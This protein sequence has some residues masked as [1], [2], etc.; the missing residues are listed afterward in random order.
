VIVRH[1]GWILAAAMLWAARAEAQS[2]LASRLT[3]FLEE[4]Y[5]TS[6][7]LGHEGSPLQPQL[8]FSPELD[9]R[10]K[11]QTF[12]LGG[13]YAPILLVPHGDGAG[14]PTVDHTL[15]LDARRLLGPRL[16]V[17]GAGQ[18][19]RVTDPAHLPRQWGLGLVAA[20]GMI[21]GGVQGW[22][23]VALDRRWSVRAMYRMEAT[24][25]LAEGLAPGFLHAPEAELE[26]RLD[27]RTTLGALYRLQSFHFDSERSTSHGLA[28]HLV[29]RWTRTL[30]LEA[31]AGPTLFAQDGGGSG[32]H[33]RFSV[34]LLQEASR[35]VEWRLGAGHDLV[36]ASG[37][38]AAL[39]ASHVSG[40]V[41]WQVT[42]SVRLQGTVYAFRN[43]RLPPDGSFSW[44]GSGPMDHGLAASAGAAWSP[45]RGWSLQAGVGR[46]LQ[47]GEPARPGASFDQLSLQ[48]VFTAWE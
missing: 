2:T 26:H 23:R 36:G 27:R 46:F 11:G 31:H 17:G 48:V 7:L 10:W 44:W 39:M 38:A 33:P 8:R 24:Q 32:L 1:A 41:G 6:V 47:Q 34:S 13:R 42:P 19:W 9:A 16:E 28:A 20:E 40:M 18:L 37:M 21:S 14:S 5:A 22:A 29:H 45:G 3:V 15:A 25:L 35:S 12:E 4:R 30:T 43:G